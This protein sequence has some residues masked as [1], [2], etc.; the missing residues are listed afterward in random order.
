MIFFPDFPVEIDQ[1]PPTRGNRFPQR[2]HSRLQGEFISLLGIT[3]D[4]G[5]HNI[6]PVSHAS[7]VPW[8]D[9]V[10]VQVPVLK[11]LAAI[12]AN[13][14]IALQDILAGKL[15]FLPRQSIKCRQH[16]DRRKPEAIGDRVDNGPSFGAILNAHP[17]FK[18]VS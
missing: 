14:V 11:T 18:V 9:M 1:W 13:I 5:T 12:L 7:L 8:N 2:G 16:N 10:K 15:D 4:A 3:A 6:L 17:G